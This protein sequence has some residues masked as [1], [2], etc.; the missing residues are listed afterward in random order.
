MTTVTNRRKASRV[1]FGRGID[2]QIVA[3]DGAW[4]RKCTMLDV[5]ESGARLALRMEGLN[6]KEFFLVLSS[7]GVA[8]R[9]CEL[10]W[11]NGDQVGALFMKEG[12]S[13]QKTGKPPDELS[14]A[15]VLHA[16]DCFGEKKVRGSTAT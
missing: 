3:I 2:V 11:V 10:A 16:G 12:K 8:F 14:P 6:L 15:R 7:T 13:P 5:S 1:T 4:S 9:R